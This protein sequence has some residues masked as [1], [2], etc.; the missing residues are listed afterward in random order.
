MEA[1]SIPSQA[2]A[3]RLGEL[4]VRSGDAT[5]EHVDQALELQPLLR[6]RL[7]EILVEKRWTTSKAVAVALGAQYALD[8]VDLTQVAVDTQLAA[9]VKENFAHQHQALPVRRLGDALGQVAV[10]APT[11]LHTQDELRLALGLNCRLAVADAEALP[12][13]V[14]PADPPHLSGPPPPP[15]G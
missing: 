15:R 12:P 9:L 8:F 3:L 10:A 6:K 4:L 1:A 14:N 7:G 13:S 11:N 5:Q 2:P